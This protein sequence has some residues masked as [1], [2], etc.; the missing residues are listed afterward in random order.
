[1]NPGEILTEIII[2]AQAMDAVTSY[3]KFANRE[4]IDF[5]ILG[6]AFWASTD[7]KQYRAA[8]TAVERKPLRGLQ[9]ETCLNGKDL[10]ETVLNEACDLAVQAAK[11]L[12]TSV[13]SPS[14][15]RKLMGLLLKEAARKA[16][17][18]AA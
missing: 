14:Y 7:D 5:P 9:I 11:P 1:L 15:K 18:R 17:R 2:P 6:T 10:N 13:Y 12:K 4:S 8:F 3:T 16:T